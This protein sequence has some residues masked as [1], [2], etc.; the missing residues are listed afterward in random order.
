MNFAN[1]FV[2]PFYGLVYWR[3]RSSWGSLQ[4]GSLASVL[5]SRRPC[6][7]VFTSSVILPVQISR[8]FAP[9]VRLH[10][11]LSADA[12]VPSELVP[13][14]ALHFSNRSSL[15]PATRSR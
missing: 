1:D 10:P 13:M 15:I 4:A 12:T 14:A 6:H 3:L 8:S 9:K 2:A 11:C 7:G 5:T